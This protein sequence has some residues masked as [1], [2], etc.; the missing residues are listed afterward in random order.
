MA[1]NKNFN[2]ENERD[3]YFKIVVKNMNKKDFEKWE[4]IGEHE[5]HVEDFIYN[6]FA[7]T[8]D[9]EKELAEKDLLSWVELIE[10]RKLYQAIKKLSVEDQIF[11]S[12]IFQEDKIQQ[13]LSKVYKTSQSQ[14]SDKYNKIMRKIKF[15]MSNK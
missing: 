1:L 6:N 15:Y 13:Q 14:I 12:Y 3:A 11:I 9:V 4:K 5:F 7:G 8:A 10:N 2:N